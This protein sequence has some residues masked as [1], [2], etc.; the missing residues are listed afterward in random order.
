MFFDAPKYRQV[1]RN[2]EESIAEQIDDLVER[3]TKARIPIE[4]FET[5]KPNM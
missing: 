2:L 3:F 4:R 5:E 1:T